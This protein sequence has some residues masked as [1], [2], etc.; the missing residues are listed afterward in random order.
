M[1]DDLTLNAGSGGSTLATDQAAGGEHYQQVK[2]VDGTADSTTVVA[3][4]AGVAANALR[5]ELPTDGTGV[6]GLNTGTNSIGSVNLGTFTSTATTIPAKL[7]D[8][9]SASGDMGVNCL[10]RR[11]ASPADTSGA[12]LDYESIQMD[13]GRVWVQIGSI[14]HDAA[15]GAN[16]NPTL[17]GAIAAEMDGTTLAAAA[18]AE[19]DVTYIRSDRD[20]RQLVNQSHPASST[21][22]LN[23]A[24][25][26]TATEM[27]AQ[28]GAGFSVYITALH[29]SAITAQTL[30]VHDEDDN[31]LIPL[32]YYGANT[33]T[34]RIDLSSNPIKV[35]AV[36]AVEFTSTAA[37]AHSTLIQFYIAP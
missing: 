4:G 5:V 36:K 32:Q 24:S 27:V 19:G 31:V 37:V 8:Q 21:Y 3:V 9:A 18:V 10:A 1:A 13:N 16:D 23:S 30:K 35:T 2:I 29:C 28:P 6:V 14:A 25:A 17:C 15:L 33:G 12:D 11:T 22:N 34:V 7:E 20:G 26:Q